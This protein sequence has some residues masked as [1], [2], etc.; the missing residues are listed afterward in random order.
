MK[1]YSHLEEKQ[2]SSQN[3]FDGKLLHVYSD[4]IKLPNGNTATREYMKHKGAVCILPIDRHGNVY[5]EHQFRYPLHKTII[6]LPAGKLDS[7]EEIPLEAAQR[8]LME[9]TGLRAEKWT[10]MGKFTPSCAYTDEVIHLYLAEEL[11][12]GDRHLDE[13]EMLDVEK[14]PFKELLNK[15]LSGEI[16]DGKTQ[17]LTLMTAMRNK[18]L[19]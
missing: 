13:D 16:T 1:D 14:M 5:I 6:E 19:S 10:F 15:V 17:V 9:E 3:V 11:S 4:K 7:Y 8:E 2:I 12:Q 18:I